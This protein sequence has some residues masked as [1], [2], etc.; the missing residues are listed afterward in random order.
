MDAVPDKQQNDRVMP[1]EMPYGWAPTTLQEIVL[2]PRDKVQPSPESDL[3]FIGMDHIEPHT[4]VLCGNGKFSEMKSAGVEFK[5]GDVL[6][7]RLRP[8]LNKVYTAEFEGVCSAEFIV[9]PRNEHLDSNFLKWLLHSREFVNFA[10]HPDRISGDRPRV[11]LESIGGFPIKLPPF[12]E[13]GR[14]SSK[15]AELFSEINEGEANL[16]RVQALVEHYRQSV[17]TA[18]ITGELTREGREE[19]K[20]NLETGEQLLERILMARR[21]TWEQA[22]LAKLR[23]SGK[24]PKNRKWKEKYKTPVSC[25]ASKLPKL[26]KQ[27]VWASLDQLAWNTSYGTSVKC[28][29]EEKGETVLRIPNV[30]PG[31]FILDDLKYCS[32]ELGLIDADFISRG[33]LLIVRT[34]GSR[35]ILGVG[36]VQLDNPDASRYFASYLIRFRLISNEHTLAKWVNF[37]WQSSAVRKFINRNAATSAG[38]YNISQSKLRKLPIALPPAPVMEEIVQAIEEKF[39]AVDFSA[40]NCQ[41]G[42]LRADILRMSVLRS[43]FSGQLVPQ[44]PND[45]PASVLLERI[46]HS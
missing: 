42:K 9:F 28:G 31:H 12:Q 20:N 25:D 16:K 4:T 15:I 39:V 34:N 41:S 37:Y 17:L 19:D 27:W 13:Q 7:G 11:D 46:K 35:D 21:R 43:A 5:P 44:D 36:A 40:E 30:R 8:Y 14:I 6:Y 24:E 2:R 26:P 23:T 1:N 29:Y 18:A 10:A 32:A 22:E 45:E 3:P 38:Q 33:D